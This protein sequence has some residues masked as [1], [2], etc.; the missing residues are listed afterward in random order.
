MMITYI[1]EYLQIS[2]PFGLEYLKGDWYILG[3]IRV[4][5]DDPNPCVFEKA[6]LY[7]N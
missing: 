1:S 3:L 6:L 4:K 2:L 7:L 5:V